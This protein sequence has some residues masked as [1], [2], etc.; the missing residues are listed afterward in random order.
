M[1]LITEF[2]KVT[3]RTKTILHVV[4][5]LHKNN[6]KS[7]LV[8]A[9]VISEHDLIAVS[10]KTNIKKRYIPCGIRIQNYKNYDKTA[11]KSNTRK[12]C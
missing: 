12:R 4:F 3:N 6:I 11:F 1:Q 10:C 2:P 8:L 9:T 5:M 7:T